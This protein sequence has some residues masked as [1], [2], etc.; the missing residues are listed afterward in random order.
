MDL[1]FLVIAGIAS[2]VMILVG[3]VGR[4]FFHDKVFVDLTPGLV[5]ARGQRALVKRVQPGQEYSGTVP[6]AFSPPKGLTPGLVGTVVDGVA[7]MRD[8]TAT[9]VDLARRGHLRIKAVDV[10]SRRQSDPTK[11]ARDWEVSVAAKAPDDQMETFERQ[12][13][14]SLFGQ[15]RSASTPPVRVSQW[16]SRQ[17]DDVRRLRDKLY[18]QTV[19]I[20]WYDKDPRPKTGGCLKVLG[21]VALLAWAALMLATGFTWIKLVA[22]VVLLGSGIFV[23]RRLRRRVPRTALG[24]AARIQALGFKQYLATAEAKQ[25]TFEE[26]A[27]IFSRYLPYAIVFGVAEHWAKVFGDVIEARSAEF[28]PED[29]ALVAMDFASNLVWFDA[30]DGSFDLFADGGLLDASLFEDLDLGGLADGVGGIA[31]AVGDFISDLDFDF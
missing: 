26:A 4:R 24:T 17:R 23:G 18:E 12:L 31:E 21:F 6:V 11:K 27:G 9:I 20:G 15:G 3:I 22:A 14:H 8:I 30:L 1:G 10:D 5:P 25:F 29:A 7:E 28:G 13:M 16:A 19:R 2:A